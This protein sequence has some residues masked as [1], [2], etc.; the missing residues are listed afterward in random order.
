M[1]FSVEVTGDDAHR[2]HQG[3]GVNQ[4]SLIFCYFLRRKIT[5]I[6]QI[7]QIELTELRKNTSSSRAT[8]VKNVVNSACVRLYCRNVSK[9][10]TTM[11]QEKRQFEKFVEENKDTI[12]T[13][14]YMFSKDKDEVAEL[15][16]ESLINLWKGYSRIVPD[17]LKGWVYRVCLNTCISQGRKNRRH[18]HEELTMDFSPFDDE[19]AEARSSQIRI[20]HER[21]S[22]LQL[23]DRALVLLWLEDISY[24]EIG[25]ILGISPKAV[26]VRL[27]RIKEQLKNK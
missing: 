12:Y 21:I 19:P 13:V 16:E 20:I 14:C 9:K 17:N 6:P 15:F 1:P 24:N 10:K 3:K 5:C 2:C 25:E 22:Q 8:F 11:E 4:L 23:L 26:S 18:A 7:I 27:V